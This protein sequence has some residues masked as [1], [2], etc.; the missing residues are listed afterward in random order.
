MPKDAKISELTVSRSQILEYLGCGYRWDLS[1][2][3]GIASTKV[4]EALDQGSAVHRA[5]KEVI[6]AYANTQM[7]KL[8]FTPG[9]VRANIIGGVSAWAQEER[10]RRGKFLTDETRED[11]ETIKR[12]AVGIAEK[13]IENINLPEWEI[14]TYNGL[15]LF[16]VEIV[17]PLPPWKGFRTIPDLVARPKREGKNAP[18]WLIDWKTR[19]SFEQD[20]AE[21]INLQFASMQHVLLI[22][23]PKLLIEG[24]ILW[25]IKDQGPRMPSQNKDGSMSRQAIV[26]D[27]PTYEAALRKAK[28][29]PADY[30]DMKEKL[31]LIEW[32]RALKEH[33]DTALCRSVWHEIIVPAARRMANDPQVIRRWSYLPF[34]CKGCWAKDF[35][36][37][38]LR[39]DDTEF[40]LESDYIDTRNPRKERNLGENRRKFELTK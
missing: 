4:R 19:G 31:A 33:R 14:A 38:E 16:E 1:F 27:W 13:A 20:D 7:R 15:P 3:R 9:M 30:Q 26:T 12:A 18:Y 21:E 32:F 28:L 40:L 22:E 24:S 6:G 10:D 34:C 5:I 17:T 29:N 39:G 11:I 8:K 2:R 37:T 35:C 36:L 23:M 25:Q